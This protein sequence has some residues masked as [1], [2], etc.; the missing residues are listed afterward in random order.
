MLAGSHFVQ[1]KITGSSRTHES[2]TTVGQTYIG[3]IAYMPASRRGYRFCLVIVERLT[4]FISAIPLKSLTSESTSDAIRLFISV[5]SFTMANFS[6]DFG[7]EFSSKFTSQL[8]SM[9]IN[10]TSRIPKGLSPKV[11]LRLRLKFSSKL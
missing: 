11:M 8:N 3:D 6:S 4:S 7:P 10:H 1:A 2:D 9:G 5:I